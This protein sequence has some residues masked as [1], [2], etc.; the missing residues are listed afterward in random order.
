[1][2]E[3]LAALVDKAHSLSAAGSLSLEEAAETA[4]TMFLDGARQT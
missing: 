4:V 3:M 1:L 2:F